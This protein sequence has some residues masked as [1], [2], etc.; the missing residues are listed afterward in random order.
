MLDVQIKIEIQLSPIWARICLLCSVIS[1]GEACSVPFRGN[2]DQPKVLEYV[3]FRT[4]GLA[5]RPRG[6]P[7]PLG[8]I[9]GRSYEVAVI[10]MNGLKINLHADFDNRLLELHAPHAEITPGL[11]FGVWNPFWRF[12]T[13][14]ACQL[15]PHPLGRTPTERFEV[16]SLPH[17]HELIVSPSLPNYL[18]VLPIFE[19]FCGVLVSILTFHGRGKAA[20]YDSYSILA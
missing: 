11:H 9:R 10:I 4:L 5:A 2:T 8:K 20:R 17:W 3:V 15:N 19:S 14:S 13:T 16:S 6:K 18:C 1:V 12:N 7:T